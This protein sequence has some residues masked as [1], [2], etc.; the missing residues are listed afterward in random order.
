MQI[1]APHSETHLTPQLMEKWLTLIHR[2]TEAKLITFRERM[3]LLYLYTQ[4]EKNL[5]PTP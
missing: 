5:P 3:L 1:K 2:A 4:I